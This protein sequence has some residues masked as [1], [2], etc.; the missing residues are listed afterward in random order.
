MATGNLG[1]GVTQGHTRSTRVT[2]P[3]GLAL[4]IAHTKT[5]MLQQVYE[6][7][8]LTTAVLC[9]SMCLE[10]NSLLCTMAAF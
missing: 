4:G 7:A 2:L 3:T 9:T 5:P 6:S 10:A 1:L 8:L